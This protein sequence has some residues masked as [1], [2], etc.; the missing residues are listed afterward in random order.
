M[1]S[2]H[3]HESLKVLFYLWCNLDS[4]RAFGFSSLADWTDIHRG[5]KGILN[6][7]TV[8]NY[9]KNGNRTRR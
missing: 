2:L 3:I 9:M 7:A 8:P 5:I 4:K 6:S 1:D